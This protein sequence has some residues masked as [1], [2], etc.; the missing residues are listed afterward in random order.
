MV[1]PLSTSTWVVT[2]NISHQTI[3]T[4]LKVNADLV[5]K[6]RV[7]ARVLSLRSE[8]VPF[9]VLRYIE[10]SGLNKVRSIEG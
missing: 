5:G 9:S 6:L 4:S 7:M 1:C 3:S 8:W 10:G 2:V